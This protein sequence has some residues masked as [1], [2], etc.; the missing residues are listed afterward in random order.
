MRTF[1]EIVKESSGGKSA[2]LY[3]DINDFRSDQA[4]WVQDQI[5]ELEVKCIEQ[6][7]GEGQGDTIYAVYESTEGGVKKFYRA[8]GWYAS[9][10]GAEFDRFIE[11]EPYQETVTKFKEV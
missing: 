7:G 9:Y 4:D 8:E 10:A 11:V 3:G 6:F 1:K 5:D 2:L